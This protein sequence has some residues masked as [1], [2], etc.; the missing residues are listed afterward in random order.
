MKFLFYIYVFLPIFGFISCNSASSKAENDKSIIIAESKNSK[1]DIKA[2]FYGIHNKA[3]DSNEL[4]YKVI[5]YIIFK[6]EKSGKEIK[7][8]APEKQTEQA[9]D[10]YFTDIWS[11]NEEYLILPIG[12]FEGLAV[13]E[14]KD[15]LD[16]IKLN[17]Y[18]DKIKVKSENSGWFWHDFEKW[19]DDS[20]FSFRAGLSGDMF[21]FKYSIANA[22]LYCYQEKCEERN[23][24]LNNKIEIKAIKKG[25]VEPKKIH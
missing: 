10:L 21:A 19:E 2:I 12:K 25:D 24:G 6:D 4:D 23:I 22:E 17:K 7:Y 13:F 9:T 16:N 5:R 8:V 15:A 1:Y 18:F 20:T 14:A 11:P 3:T